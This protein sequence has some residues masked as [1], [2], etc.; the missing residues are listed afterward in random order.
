MAKIK[1]L[2]IL[3]LLILLVACEIKPKGTGSK[4]LQKITLNQFATETG[5]DI[6]IAREI[7][8][9][10]TGSPVDLNDF[11]A[12]TTT[13]VWPLIHCGNVLNYTWVAPSGIQ[14]AD[15][16]D[17][18]AYN[19]F[20][21][22][23]LNPIDGAIIE[24]DSYADPIA[25]ADQVESAIQKH[26]D[27]S[28]EHLRTAPQ[29]DANNHSYTMLSGWGGGGAYIAMSAELEDNKVVIEVGSL[30]YE[31]ETI[32]YQGTL[33]LEFVEENVKYLSFTMNS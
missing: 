2:A 12:L 29:Y 23:D 28:V 3:F 18:C 19:N 13:Y 1:R 10:L 7:G 17:I 4:D 21:Q 5:F 26:F 31:S 11:T 6:D 14:A 25:P 30:G 32:S 22:K 27:V 33:E 24:G 9:N 20:L 8:P 16:I 15:L